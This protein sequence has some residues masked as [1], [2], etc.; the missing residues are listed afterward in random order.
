LDSLVVSRAF[1]PWREEATGN[2]APELV[3]SQDAAVPKQAVN[4]DAPQ[5]P[6]IHML[7]LQRFRRQCRLTACGFLGGSDA[8]APM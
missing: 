3:P 8:E 1:A 6:Y 2:P 7:C 4:A 5:S